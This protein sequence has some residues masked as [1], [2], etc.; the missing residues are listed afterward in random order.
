MASLAAAQVDA[1]LDRI[2]LDPTEVRGTDRDRM[3]VAELQSAHVHHVPFENLGIVGDPF[4]DD[5]RGSARVSLAVE[6]LYAKIVERHRGG[7]C[8][9]LNGL[10]TALLDGL[11]FDVD[12]AAA[13]ILP[14]D[15][16]P[17]TPANHHVIV[18]HL[19][20]DYVVD[21]G[22][23]VPQMRHPTPLTG[24]ATTRD[25]TGVRW[26]VRASDRPQYRLQ[27]EYQR[28]EEAWT[29]RHV[30]DP[31]PR[32]FSYFH[33][34]NDYLSQAPESLFTTNAFAFIQTQTGYKE[35]RT[36]TYTVAEQGEVEEREITPDEWYDR[37]ETE[38]GIEELRRD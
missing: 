9:E 26:R 37:L 24:A 10:F 11:G 38:F 6:D 14:E 8:Y 20:E 35:L 17:D 33:A 2:G 15:G 23:A 19:E 16:D 4:T 32:P 29:P 22:M 28:G 3:L 36:D 5:G 12:R 7:Y 27:A 34:S 18:A 21:V 25:G 30:F 1:Y 13:M 31:T